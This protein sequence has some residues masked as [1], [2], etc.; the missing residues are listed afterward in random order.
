MPGHHRAD[1]QQVVADVGAQQARAVAAAGMFCCPAGTE[2]LRPL[3][4]LLLVGSAQPLPVRVL[5]L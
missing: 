5:R 1:L 2:K 4:R 3:Q